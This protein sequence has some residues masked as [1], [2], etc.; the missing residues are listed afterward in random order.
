[1]IASNIDFIYRRDVEKFCK[2]FKIYFLNIYSRFC[3]E[4]LL[5]KYY[6][7]ALIFIDKYFFTAKVWKP[8]FKKHVPKSQV[9]SFIAFYTCWL[10]L[11]LLMFLIFLNSQGIKLFK[12][13]FWI[14]KIISKKLMAFLVKIETDS[15]QFILD[16][17]HTILAY[18][19]FFHDDN[20]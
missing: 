16:Y 9:V 6:F 17:N 3:S 19:A 5:I 7:C 11:L 2:H 10:I 1:L 14:D 13:V 4:F 20:K 18:F 12:P 15:D 8:I